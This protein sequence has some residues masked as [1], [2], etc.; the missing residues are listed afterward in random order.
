M[1]PHT[2]RL[3]NYPIFFHHVRTIRKIDR[4]FSLG[5]EA[6]TFEN[7]QVDSGDAHGDLR[8]QGEASSIHEEPGMKT[9]DLYLSIQ[10]TQVTLDWLDKLNSQ[11]SIPCE[12]ND[13]D[14]LA[15]SA[16][17]T[18]IA[19]TL[20]ATEKRLCALK[21]ELHLLLESQLP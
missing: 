3:N 14:L 13:Q 5:S 11:T 16:I 17:A 10:Q 18:H 1:I 7:S 4:T 20:T 9:K 21:K 2:A 8:L 15:M 19:D 12:V 6:A